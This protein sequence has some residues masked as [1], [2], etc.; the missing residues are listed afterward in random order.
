MQKHVTKQDRVLVNFQIFFFTFR[1]KWVGR[2]MGN[3]TFYWDG[4]IKPRSLKD[5]WAVN[6][7]QQDAFK[8]QFDRIMSQKVHKNVT[9]W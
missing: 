4:L 2:A 3:E 1:K 5:C 9:I 7:V 8:K 6:C